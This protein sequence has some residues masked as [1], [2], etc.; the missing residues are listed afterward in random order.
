[1]DNEVDLRIADRDVLIAIIVRQQ[2]II[3]RLEKG[4]AQLEG[5]AKP[6]GSRRMPSTTVALTFG[7]IGP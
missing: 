5:P 3:E 4:M 7:R 2:A 1:M 6:S